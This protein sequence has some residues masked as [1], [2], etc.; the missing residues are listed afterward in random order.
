MGRENAGKAYKDV[1]AEMEE[2]ET[3]EEEHSDTEPDENREGQPI[4]KNPAYGGL[5]Y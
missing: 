4:P 3:V 1:E 2:Y 5:D